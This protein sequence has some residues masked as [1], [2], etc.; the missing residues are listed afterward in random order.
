M[1]FDPEH[2]QKMLDLISEFIIQKAK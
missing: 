2:F 1:I